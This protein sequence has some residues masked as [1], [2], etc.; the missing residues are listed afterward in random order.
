MFNWL[1]NLMTRRTAIGDGRSNPALQFA[2]QQAAVI[3]DELPGKDQIDE[4]SRH[5][6]ARQLYLDLHEIFNAG[7]PADTARQKLAPQVL[8]FALLKVILI[9]P[10]PKTDDSG[11]RGL[12]GITGELNAHIASLVRHDTDLHTALFENSESESS[13]QIEQLLYQAYWRCCW[14][15]ETFNSARKDLGDVFQDGDWFLPFVY[16]ACANQENSYRLDIG[17]PPA[18]E[19]PLAMTA[20]VAYSLFTDIVLSGARQPL[21][22]WS[23]YHR[24]RSIPMPD[25]DGKT[26]LKY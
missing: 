10:H 13:E 5:R 18:F 7:S 21:F 11:L 17:M 19:A 14:C 8:R 25:F 4:R 1:G 16:A 20:P 22:E 9:P 12:P 2:V 6:L 3:F 26:T 15:L 24:G 23:E